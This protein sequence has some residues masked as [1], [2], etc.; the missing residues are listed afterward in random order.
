MR[1]KIVPVLIALSV[2]LNIGVA[3][4]WIA[5]AVNEFQAS[6]GER[7]DD[8]AEGVWSPLHR[9]LGVA[10]EQWSLLETGL[11]KFQQNSESLCLEI[12][13]R[14]RE[15]I[16]LIASAQPD[17]DAIKAKQEEIRRGQQQMQRLVVDHLLAEKEVLTPEQQDQLFEMMR[18]RSTCPARGLFRGLME[19]PD[20]PP[21]SEGTH[22]TTDGKR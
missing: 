17:R 1:W 19:S 13:N 7:I 4:V 6:R 12:N 9:S 18:D 3:G 2:T 15:L 14:R 21:P 11:L 16:D 5:H 22:F 8:S 20:M 10:E